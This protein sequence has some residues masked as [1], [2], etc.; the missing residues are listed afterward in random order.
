MEE[1][2]H[3]LLSSKPPEE[4]ESLLQFFGL[5]AASNVAAAGES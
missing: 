2:V 4:R 3:V 5:T 1:V